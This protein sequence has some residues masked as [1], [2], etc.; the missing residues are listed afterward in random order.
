M[1]SLRNIFLS[2]FAKFY[3]KKFKGRA[4]LL[5]FCYRYR[6]Q[7]IVFEFVMYATFSLLHLLCHD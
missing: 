1:Q 4:T 6:I 7:H 5:E 3:R 2:T